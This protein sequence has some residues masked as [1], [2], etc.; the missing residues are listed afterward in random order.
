M[1]TL[2]NTA[3]KPSS[4]KVWWQRTSRTRSAYIYLIPALVVMG[5][6][7]FYPMFYQVWMSF[8]DYGIKNLRWDSPAPNWVGVKNYIDIFTG[9]IAD[10]LPNFDFLKLLG[11]NLIWTFTNVP[12]H[13]VLGVLIAV[14]L[15]VKGMW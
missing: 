11:F 10:K 8:T 15:N 2:P 5:V 3:P 14:L 12:I 6:I 4:F 1:A 7:T 13:V 9:V